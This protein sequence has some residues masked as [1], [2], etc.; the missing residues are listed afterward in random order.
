[1][2][3]RAF[4]L[5]ELLV[6]IGLI[7][8]ATVLLMPPHIGHSRHNARKSACQNNLKQLGVAMKQ[9]QQDF[10]EKYPLIAAEPITG[11]SEAILP[12]LKDPQRFQCPTHAS[13]KTDAPMQAGYNDYFYN[14]NF[15]VRDKQGRWAGASGDLLGHAFQ[16]ILLG[17]GGDE[18]GNKGYNA[19]YNQCGDGTALTSNNKPCARSRPSRAILPSAQ[20]HLGGA[21]FAFADGHVKWFRGDSISSCRRISNNGSTQKSVGGSFTFSLL[22]K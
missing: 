10:D 3:R 1:M 12:Y 7:C 6:V 18:N 16:T 21:N 14:A 9:Y 8:V 22:A 5:V 4:T 19:T 17:E 20:I 11:W 2:K 15:L 13:V